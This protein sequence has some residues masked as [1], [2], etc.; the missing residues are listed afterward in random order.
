MRTA[1]LQALLCATIFFLSCSDGTR[2]SEW[3]GTVADSAGIPVAQNPVEGMWATGEGWT[4]AEELSIGSMEGDLPYQF[5]QIGGVDVDAAGNVY[6]AD[7]QAQEIRVFDAA[8]AH[9]RTIGAPGAGPGELSQAVTGVFVVGEDVV[10]PDL[11]NARV[12]RFSVS[13]DFIAS[14]LIDLAKGVPL[15]LDMTAGGRLAGQ[16][17]ALNA[18]DTTAEPSGDPIVTLPLGGEAA[19]TLAV[20]PPGQSVQFRGGQAR[21]RLYDPE[22]IWDADPDG[23]LVS[24]MN[25]AWRFVAWGPEGDIRRVVT[26]PYERKAFTDRDAQVFRDALAELM[27]QQ[28][29]PPEA[30][31]ALLAQMEFAD[32]YPAFVSLALGPLGSLWVQHIRSGDELVGAEGTF[33]IQ[34]LGSTDWSVFDDQGRYLGV[35]TFPGK[36]QPLRAIGDRFYGI[37]RDEMDVQSLKVYRVVT[38][39]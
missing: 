1:A 13:G 21:I 34:D 33:D 25:D 8:G 9:V 17:R 18:A 30:A 4:V 11:G 6:I 39:A 2:D 28:G 7:I 35:V 19:D 12:S 26:R 37:A 23:R 38:G 36:Y 24:G 5:G 16:Y 15:R 10:V 3:A 27:R 14:D 29:T 20:L 32:Y 22:P 31:Q